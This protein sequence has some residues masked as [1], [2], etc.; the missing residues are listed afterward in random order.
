MLE[1]SSQARLVVL[2][3]ESLARHS[4]TLADAIIEVATSEQIEFI[5][6]H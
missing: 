2:S 6:F 1:S 5:D 3:T 4:I